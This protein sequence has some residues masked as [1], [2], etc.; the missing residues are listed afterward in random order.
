VEL[1]VSGGL[2]RRSLEVN[3]GKV[4]TGQRLARLVSHEADPFG[5]PIRKVVR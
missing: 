4:G 1:D 3:G 5:Q 2:S